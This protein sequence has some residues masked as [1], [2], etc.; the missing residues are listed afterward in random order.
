MPEHRPLAHLC[1]ERGWTNDPTGPVRW[2]GRTHLFHQY[3]P[4]GPYWDL[5]HWGH[6]VTDDLVT[7]ERRPIA[8]TPSPQGPDADGCFSGCVVVDG[9]EAVM[10]YTGVVGP[11]APGQQQA[12]CLARST[13]PML[14][15]WIKDDTNPV[16][17][18][19]AGADLGFRDPFVWREEGRWWQAVGAG[20]R[21]S[22]GSVRLYSSTDLREW[23]EE[24]PLLVKADLERLDATVWTGSTW[25]C[26]VLVR[27][28][29]LDV[30][31]LSIHDDRSHHPLAVI[32][33]LEAQRFRPIRMQRLDLG[34][35]VYAPCVLQ[36]SDGTA[37]SWAWSW[38]ARS[39]ERQRDAGWAGVLTFPRI[40][41]VR[42]DQLHVRPLP[43]LAELREAALPVERRPTD[44]GWT[45]PDVRGDVLD[46]EIDLGPEADTIDLHVRQ[47]PDR[48]ETT[49]ISVDRP[50]R[51]LRLDRS[52]SSLAPDVEAGIHDG[53]LAGDQPVEHVRVLV[54]RSIVEVFVDDRTALTARIYPSRSDSDRIEIV[55]TP[56]AVSAVTVRA[57]TLGPLWKT[58]TSGRSGAVGRNATTGAER[59]DRSRPGSDGGTIG[60]PR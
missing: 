40:L 57:W 38:E 55:G 60:D 13:D 12:T 8:L 7:W 37:I 2:N 5:P 17:T 59:G 29:D 28:V 56:R 16:T 25:E 24:E 1:P 14:D 21:A 48:A 35:D 23:T 34:P 36:Q 9:T 22:G 53:E 32:G 30:L 50:N 18:A 15:H 42:A 4:A 44:E 58:S 54:D 45:A 41:E 3:N 33:T 10:A 51:R 26:P 6:F 46:L 31:L 52:R 47:S 20:S 27:G 43:H 19:P 11:H 39:A 49:I